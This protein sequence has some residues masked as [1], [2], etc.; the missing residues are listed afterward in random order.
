[1]K[2]LYIKKQDSEANKI[3]IQ[4]STYGSLKSNGYALKVSTAAHSDWPLMG[5][6]KY[7]VL[8]WNTV[9]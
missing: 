1:M 3:L 4:V 7:R 6:S 9:L 2:T 8:C 5:M